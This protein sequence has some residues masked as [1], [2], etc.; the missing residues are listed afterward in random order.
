MRSKA[1]ALQPDFIKPSLLP[2]LGLGEQC[3]LS[4][5]SSIACEHCRKALS[6]LLRPKLEPRRLTALQVG[7]TR[8]RVCK[9][10]TDR[11]GKGSLPP[12]D[13]SEDFYFYHCEF[14]VFTLPVPSLHGILAVIK[15]CLFYVALLCFMQKKKKRIKNVP[16]DQILKINTGPFQECR[17]M[18]TI[19]FVAGV[20]VCRHL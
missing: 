1:H 4:S 6:R 15:K 20:N 2:C 13:V 8:T 10:L 9:P 19:Y 11:I 7:P 17:H 12:A 18:V 14:S 3:S 16:C 5:R